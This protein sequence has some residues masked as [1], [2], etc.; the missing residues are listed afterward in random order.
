MNVS[1]TVFSPKKSKSSVF[2]NESSTSLLKLPAGTVKEKFS[3]FSSPPFA[4]TVTV[5]SGGSFS[6]GPVGSSFLQLFRTIKFIPIIER[7]FVLILINTIKYEK[8]TY[9]QCSSEV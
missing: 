6:S 2:D 5:D 7:M 4:P 8:C 9:Y 1:E 3:A